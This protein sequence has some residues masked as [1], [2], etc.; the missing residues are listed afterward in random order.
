MLQKMFWL[1][2]SLFLLQSC[3]KTGKPPTA[4]IAPVGEE[5]KVCNG[6]N[7]CYIKDDVAR[8]F[9]AKWRRIPASPGSAEKI[10]IY[11]E[12]NQGI[13]QVEIDVYSVSPGFFGVTADRPAQGDATFTYF[14]GPLKLKAGAGMVEITD[15][16]EE[17]NTLTGSFYA[18]A[19]KNDTAYKFTEGNMVN[20]PMK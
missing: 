15:I 10:H 1:S 13:F 19:V 18:T 5:V 6:M 3:D 20:V 7:F 8:G 16:N 12:E 14:D 9:N 2:V 4:V 11:Y 17:D